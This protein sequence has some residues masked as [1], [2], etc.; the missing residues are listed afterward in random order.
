MRG[1]TASWADT[2]SYAS[3]DLAHVLDPLG[4]PIETR[5]LTKAAKGHRRPSLNPTAQSTDSY[6]H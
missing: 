1:C 3:V 2:V 5:I 4:T 6:T